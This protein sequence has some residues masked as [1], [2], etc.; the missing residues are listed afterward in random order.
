MGSVRGGPPA[1]GRSVE[2]F[3]SPGGGRGG[4]GYGYAGMRPPGA[5]YP[6][7]WGV[8]DYG[9]TS[10]DLGQGPAK[11]G[12]ERSKSFS[13]GGGNWDMGLLI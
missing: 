10:M 13:Q 6:P 3:L 2:N 5:I 8:S 11:K 12:V 4:V 9:L 7:G 1:R